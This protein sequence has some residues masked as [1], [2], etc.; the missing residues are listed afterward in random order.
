MY[1]RGIRVYSQNAGDGG[2]HHL[3]A[4]ARPTY[5][6]SVQVLI[7]PDAEDYNTGARN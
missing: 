6:K 5:K 2:M 4:Q 3:L 1:L 7:H